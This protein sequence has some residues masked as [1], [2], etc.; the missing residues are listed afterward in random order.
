M[1]T[2]Y[3]EEVQYKAAMKFLIPSPKGIVKR[4]SYIGTIIF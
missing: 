3:G 4:G 2:G 1:P